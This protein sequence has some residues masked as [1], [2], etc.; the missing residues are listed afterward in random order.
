MTES[1]EKILAYVA[2]RLLAEPS[3]LHDSA[4]FLAF[5]ISLAQKLI[6]ETGGIT[7]LRVIYCGADGSRKNFAPSQALRICFLQNTTGPITS[8]RSSAR[9]VFASLIAETH[10]AGGFDPLE[11]Q[12]RHRLANLTTIL[13]PAVTP[14]VAV[15][16]QGKGNFCL[17]RKGT[18]KRLWR[19]AAP[20]RKLLTLLSRKPLRW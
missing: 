6:D 10:F 20:L 2:H 1:K 12:Y 3:C 14:S 4:K 17:W 15:L 11:P 9:E 13:V 7:S 8:D 5:S 19:G 18:H 16:L